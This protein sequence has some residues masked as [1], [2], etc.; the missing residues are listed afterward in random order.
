MEF[1]WPTMGRGEGADASRHAVVRD[2][3]QSRHLSQWLDGVDHAAG[4]CVGTGAEGD[5]ARKLQLGALRPHQGLLS[6][7]RSGE[8]DARKTQA[9]GGALVGGSRPEQRLAAELQ[10]A[11]DGPGGFPAT[12]PDPRAH[13]FYL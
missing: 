10:S 7:Q 5:Y 2:V 12:E 4:V 9:N 1:R 13:A 6:G 3:W 11:G 8:G